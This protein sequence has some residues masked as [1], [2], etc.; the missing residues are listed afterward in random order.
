MSA[1]KERNAVGSFAECCIPSHSDDN[2]VQGIRQK[3]S[4]AVFGFRIAIEDGTMKK[5]AKH[6]SL[7]ES[8]KALF[9]VV[10]AARL[11]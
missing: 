1:R 10:I 2:S 8:V 7:L 6:S 3:L 4:N 11:S 9:F 5:R